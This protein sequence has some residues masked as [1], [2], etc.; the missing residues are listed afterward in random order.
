VL[1]THDQDEALVVSD[2][3]MVMREGAIEQMGPP[4]EVYERPVSRFVAEFLGAANLI[5]AE[6]EPAGGARVTTPLGAFVLRAA[7]AWRRGTLAIRP[8]RVGVRE[9]PPARNGL[10]VTV[11]DAIYRGDHLDVW[12]EPG[13]LRLRTPPSQAVERGQ[14]LWIELPAEY[15]EALVD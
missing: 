6:R 5:P 3:I 4:R 8:E 14:T 10:R 2:R 11:R 1:V 13:P 7:P 15:L 12:V 9:A